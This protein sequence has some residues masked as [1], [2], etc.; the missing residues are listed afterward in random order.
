M[1]SIKIELLKV[2]YQYYPIGRPYENELYA[3]YHK[4]RSIIED[5]INLLTKGGQIA[6]W[7]SVVSD[8]EK[9]LEC[10][11]VLDMS[12]YQFPNLVLILVHPESENSGILQ[13]NNTCLVIS[14]LTD[15]YT[16][17]H[18]SIFLFKEYLSLEGSVAKTLL[19]GAKNSNDDEKNII[20]NL[21]IIMSR[22]YPN[23]KFVEHD[24]LFNVKISGG[25][26]HGEDSDT[27]KS[28]YPLY[29][30]LFGLDT[31]SEES[32]ILE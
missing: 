8:T 29:N 26:P 32:N 14:L 4:L 11:A 3:G 13:K 12:S 20:D 15:Y 21:Q 31:H 10:K 22:H 16:I 1:A 24:L 30:F 19:Y 23:H 28:E 18:Q 9:K 5:K 27:M 7:V 6:S 2:I 17:Y 25:L